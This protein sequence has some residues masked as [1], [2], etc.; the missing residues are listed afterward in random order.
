MIARTMILFTYL[1]AALVSTGADVRAA[2]ARHDPRIGKGTGPSKYS[3]YSIGVLTGYQASQATGIN[4]SRAVIGEVCCTSGLGTLSPQAVE[5]QFSTQTLAGL[6]PTGTNGATQSYANAINN[7]GTV[8][9]QVWFSIMDGACS[10]FAVA[11]TFV[12]PSFNVPG[13]GCP[14]N[15][16]T[17]LNNNGA[18]V[19]DV[20]EILPLLSGA[21]VSNQGVASIIGPGTVSQVNDLGTAVGQDTNSIATLYTISTPGVSAEIGTLGGSTSTAEAIADSGLVVG[22]SSLNKG[23]SVQHAFEY[24]QDY[25]YDFGTPIGT[26]PITTSSN[27]VSV[28]N[29]N[30]F[31]G[32]Y[33][34]SRVGGAFVYAEYQMRDLTN[35]IQNNS[36]WT[37]KTASGINDCGDI[38]GTGYFNGQQLGYL[39]KPINAN[40]QKQREKFGCTY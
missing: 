19:G 3:V 9:G 31:V 11:A 10:G 24:Y 28:N 30:E 13:T 5:Y 34:G 6:G 22:Q 17:G 8:V 40:N 7:A 2:P 35:L 12:G 16:A 29:F 20:Y 21:F 27:A 14:R 25:M 33:S 32:T 23:S 39:A 36:G 38:V 26:N 1:L 18:V 15:S 37:L 4:N